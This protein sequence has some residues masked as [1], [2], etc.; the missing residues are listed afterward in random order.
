MRLECL[1]AA[2]PGLAAPRIEINRAH[3]VAR[4]VRNALALSHGILKCPVDSTR[5]DRD[6]L[7]AQID[8][9]PGPTPTRIDFGR[10]LPAE[11]GRTQVVS[12]DSILSLC[13][14]QA[15]AI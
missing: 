3:D 6:H 13:D 10:H 1:V 5:L 15:I 14:P 12:R 7:P 4:A 11:Q 8:K 9:A 2:A